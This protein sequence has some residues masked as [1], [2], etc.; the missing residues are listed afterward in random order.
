MTNEICISAYVKEYSTNLHLV[1]KT[2]STQKWFILVCF[3]IVVIEKPVFATQSFKSCIRN[4][5][6]FHVMKLQTTNIKSFTTNS[7]LDLSNLPT[8]ELFFLTTYDVPLLYKS[9][10][11][12]FSLLPDFGDVLPLI[13]K[14]T[15]IVTFLNVNSLKN[16]E[17]AR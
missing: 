17:S 4:R 15:Y 9:V 2:R 10:T 7:K 12:N 1:Q 13:F 11:Q 6:T 3:I 5:R 16:F 8:S 14:H